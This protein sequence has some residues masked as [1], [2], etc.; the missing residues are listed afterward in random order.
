MDFKLNPEQVMLQDSVRRFI[1]RSYSF[2]SRMRQVRQRDMRA[3][4]QTF[5]DN[6]WLA[7]GI[8]EIYGGIGGDGLDAAVIAQELGQA[9]VLEPFAGAAVFPAQVLLAAGSEPHNARYLPSLIEGRLRISVAYSEASSRGNPAVVSLRADRD[10]EVGGY[11]LRG[12]KTLVIGGADADIFLVSARLFDEFGAEKGITI[13]LVKS[14][15]PGLIK[16]VQKLHDGSV[17][18]ELAF[19]DV[20][21]IDGETVGGLGEGLPALQYGYCCAVSTL[22]AELV[23]VMEKV[24]DMTAEYLKTR[25]QFGVA[26]GSFQ[27]LQHRIVDMAADLEVARS[28]L[29]SLL[30]SLQNDALDSR[31]N[32]V[33]EAKSLI[34]RLAKSVC[35]QAIQ[36]HGGIGMTDEFSIGHYFK[37]AVVA[38]IIFGTGDQHDAIRM[39]SMKSISTRS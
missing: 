34:G 17:A 22:C 23:G 21:V 20:R 10:S 30:E 31:L 36:L 7:T 11:L 24:I 3:H 33:S 35:G 26:I 39:E 9:L 37:R 12:R 29:Y 38:D 15:A 14:D 19:E 13:F 28:M 5:S 18:A 2:D 4:W 1:E 8:P 16:R 27:A 6:G 25:Q 32:M